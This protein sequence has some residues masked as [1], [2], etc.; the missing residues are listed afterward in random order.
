MCWS[1]RFPPGALRRCLRQG[2]TSRTTCDWRALCPGLRLKANA[3]SVA[4]RILKLGLQ[5]ERLNDSSSSSMK[6]MS[7]SILLRAADID[8]SYAGVHAL[9]KASFELRAGEV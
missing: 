5:T 4:T 2:R 9:K 1:R 3:R 7:D 6:I 8:K